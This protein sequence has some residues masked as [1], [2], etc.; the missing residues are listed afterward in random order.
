MPACVCVLLPSRSHQT[1]N[2]SV[3]ADQPAAKQKK[4]KRKLNKQ[5]GRLLWF[6]SPDLSPQFQ[7]CVAGAGE[8]VGTSVQEQ[9]EDST[10]QR[11]FS[12]V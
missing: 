12:L 7:C 11:G 5:K 10:G 9:R 6:G 8:V 4:K 2:Q 1:C 3:W